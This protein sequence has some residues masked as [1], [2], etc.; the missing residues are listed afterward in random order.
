MSLTLRSK[1]IFGIALIEGMLLLALIFTAIQYITHSL[2]EGLQKRAQTTTQLFAAMSKDAVLSYDLASLEAFTREVL[3]NPDIEYARV[4]DVDGNLFAQAGDANLL[5]R[6]F[7]Q[8]ISLEEVDDGVFDSY[9]LVRE[10]NQT[11]GRV[12]IGINISGVLGSLGKIRNWTAGIAITE[13]FLVALFSYLLGTYLTNQ[14]G[15]LQKASSHATEALESGEFSEALI[16]INSKD[17][18]GDVARAFNQ[19]INA[20]QEKS[21]QT[22]IYQSRLEELNQSLEEK[23]AFRTQALANNI[24]NLKEVNVQLKLAQDKLVQAEKLSSMGQ[25]A[26]GLAHE[27]NNPISFLSS[28]LDPLVH[29]IGVYEQILAEVKQVLNEEDTSVKKTLEDNIQSLISDNDVNFIQEDMQ[30]LLGDMEE[31]LQRVTDIV[32]NMAVFSRVDGDKK[33]TFNINRC[34]ESTYKM[35]KKQLSSKAAVSIDL[36]EVS[37]IEM[38]VGKINQVLTNLMIN[39]GQSISDKGEIKIST[40]QKDNKIMIIVSDTGC[41]ISKENLNKIFDPFYTTKKVGE[42]TGLGLAISYDIVKEH[43]GELS[44]ESEIDR[45][46][47]FTL[48]LPLN[49]TVLH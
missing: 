31:G 44:V 13:M 30:A 38:N 45:G 17:E 15:K 18:L 35:V 42:G 4:L 7:E 26:A 34:V 22:R 28:N 2:N 29:Y 3:S 41:G 27:I 16:D 39:A 21:E 9:A 19:M 8:D 40:R 20:L 10:G 47:V 43:N 49:A 48:S 23:V 12:E 6:G 24:E 37:E 14:L 25:L 32:R 1:T 36:G 11:Y 46:T 33:Q 5:T